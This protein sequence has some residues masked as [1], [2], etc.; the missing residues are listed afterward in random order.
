MSNQVIHNEASTSFNYVF[1]GLGAG[2]GLMLLSLLKRGLLNNKKVA[3]IESS[4]QTKND[5]TYCFWSEPDASIVTDLSP[6]ISHHYESIQIG[7]AH[8]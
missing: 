2:N 6:I 5:K 1:I 7:R 8:V 4:A 3:I